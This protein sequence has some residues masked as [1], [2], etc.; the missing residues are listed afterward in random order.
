MHDKAIVV[1]WMYDYD[2]SFRLER[3]YNTLRGVV[4]VPERSK[5]ASLNGKVEIYGDGKLL[6]KDHEVNGNKQSREIS[7]DITGV[8]D[9]R[10]VIKGDLSGF[11][12]VSVMFA[13]VTLQKTIR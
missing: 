2:A 10:L 5:G 6:W 1:G 3:S 8:E 13:D 4:G 12:S 11:L 9:L 7:V